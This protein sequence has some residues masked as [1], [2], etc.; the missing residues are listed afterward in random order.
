MFKKV[1]TRTSSG[2]PLTGLGYVYNDDLLDEILGEY[3]PSL[4]PPGKKRAAAKACHKMQQSSQQAVVPKQK[5]GKKSTEEE[6][7]EVKAPQKKAKVDEEDDESSDD[8]YFEVDRILDKRVL[9][10]KRV[11]YL[12]KWQGYSE[13]EAT[14]EPP[15]NLQNV[16]KMIKEYDIKE[17]M[18]KEGAQSLNCSSSEQTNDR[19][20]DAGNNVGKKRTLNLNNKKPIQLKGGL[21][22]GRH[23]ISKQTEELV[24][25]AQMESNEVEE[26]QGDMM[27]VTAEAGTKG[28][29]VP[30]DKQMSLLEEKKRQILE[31][32]KR[33]QEEE[34]EMLKMIETQKQQQAEALKKASQSS[35][36]A[37]PPQKLNPKQLFTQRKKT[38]PQT[39]TPKPVDKPAAEAPPVETQQPTIA[40]KPTLGVLNSVK[41]GL[42]KKKLASLPSQ[43]TTTTQQD[44]KPTEQQPIPAKPISLPQAAP[45]QPKPSVPGSFDSGDIPLRVTGAKMT[46]GQG[47]QVTIEWK[48]RADG[49]RPL[50]SVF[51]NEIVKDKCPRLLVDFY[52]SRIN[53]RSR[54]GQSSQNAGTSC[55]QKEGGV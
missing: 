30:I 17:A 41:A 22:R 1:T 39:T 38:L 28:G 8:G 32:Q 9:G 16:K 54:N 40:K 42:F 11:Q 36:A 44:P 13:A 21:R 14:W 7:V 18:Q 19:T 10:K 3:D 15:S 2:Q 27:D 34:A 4:A 24:E 49:T 23:T 43:T 52:E 6:V 20:N 5:Q 48:P 37:Q 26:V 35:Q 50:E 47:I 46:I 45:I 33:L 53:A 55:E 12:V 29:E 25:D 31:Q 51:T